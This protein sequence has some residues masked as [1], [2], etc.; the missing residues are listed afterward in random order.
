MT[1]KISAIWAQDE[2]G[3]I[4]KEGGLPWSL[5]ADL[6]HFKQTTTGHAMVMGRTTFEGMGKRVLPNRISIIL[7]HDQDYQVEH[8]RAIVLHSVEE[9]LDWYHQQERNLY[10]IGGGQVFTAFETSI[11][12]IVK[13]DIHSRFEGDT[14]FPKT[15]DLSVFEEISATMHRR[16]AENP[17]DFTVRILKRKEK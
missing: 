17:V 1:K 2:Q 15:F 6:E 8:D 4:G 14:Y 3:L 12:E 9:V 10:V 7:T 5:K 16:D 13:T 11:D